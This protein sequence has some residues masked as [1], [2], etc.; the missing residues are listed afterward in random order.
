MF[1]TC[2]CLSVLI[3]LDLLCLSDW[4]SDD[5]LDKVEKNELLLKRFA[6][7]HFM[8]ALEEF[9]ANPVAAMEK[10]KGN[11]EVEKFLM[12][13]CGLLGMYRHFKSIYCLLFML[14][15]FAILINTNMI[16]K[17]LKT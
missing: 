9:Q 11:K 12:E 8:K 4:I 13:F 3:T 7:P 15:A 10:Y 5:L 14:F 2:S 6:D 1:V 16:Q 17:V